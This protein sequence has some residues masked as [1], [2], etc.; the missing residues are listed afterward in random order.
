MIYQEFQ[1][2][3]RKLKDACQQVTNEIYVLLRLSNHIVTL[4]LGSMGNLRTIVTRD[5]HNA[6]E[7]DRLK[8]G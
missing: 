4:M 3:H 1:E 6:I 8:L 7:M 2:N 5:V